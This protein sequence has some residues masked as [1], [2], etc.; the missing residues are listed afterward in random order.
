MDAEA[1]FLDALGAGGLIRFVSPADHVDRIRAFLGGA[2]LRFFPTGI[3]DNLL[4]AGERAGGLSHVGFAVP[5]LG[6]LAE[7][8][9]RVGVGPLL[10]PF[11][12]P[13]TPAGGAM[14]VSFYRSPN[15]T[16]I[17]PQQIL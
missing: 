1:A 17:E 7:R 6:A 12:A 5:D 10:G 3:Y 9:E 16:L 8:L 13:P 2:D 15:G 4:E 14:R 11:L